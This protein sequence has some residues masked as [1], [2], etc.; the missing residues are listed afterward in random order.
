MDYEQADVI[1]NNVVF[2]TT[3]AI[4]AAEIPQPNHMR[5]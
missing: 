1:L 3:F 5:V 2:A 4:K